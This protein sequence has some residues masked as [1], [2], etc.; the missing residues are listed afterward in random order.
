MGLGI[1]L[2]ASILALA[3]AL[4]VRWV[5]IREPLPEAG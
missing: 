5:D 1:I 4:Y 2:C 3:S